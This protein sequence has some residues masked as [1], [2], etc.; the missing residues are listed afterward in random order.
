MHKHLT[1]GI[2]G[3]GQLARMSAQAASRL[4]IRTAILEREEC[5]PAGQLTHQEFVGWVDNEELV[6]Q[7]AHAC[8]VVTLENEFIDYRRLEFIESLGREV[9]PSSAVIARIQDKFIQKETLAQHGIPVPLFLPVTR[10]TSWKEL[11]ARLGS[12][13]VMKSRKMGYDGYGNAMVRSQASFDAARQKLSARHAQLMAEEFVDFTMELAVMVVRT[14]KETR[15]YP[16]VQTIQ[17]DHICSMV[18]APAP[19]DRT[20]AQRA[21]HIAI[22]A[23]EAVG[24]MGLFGVEM[25]ITSD[26]EIL[27]NEMAPRPHNSGHYTIEGCVTSQFENHVRAV[28][29]LPLG[30]TSML[31][32]YAVMVNLLGSKTP[33]PGTANLV[34][35]LRNEHAHFH[36][37]GKAASRPGRKMG[38]VT[39]LGSSLP[40][41]LTEARRLQKAIHI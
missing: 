5:S 14:K 41:L 30:S 19:I 29:G 27:V 16:V 31:A 13:V 36:L 25:F 2:L 3:G 33:K 22:A 37:Y 10:E 18:I 1:I 38:H 23:V 11:R 21:A 12:P 39:V 34:T 7:F 35:A 4:G 15:A 9:V 40:E 24:G 32:P 20:T 26:N 8:G 28:L 6:T 17:K